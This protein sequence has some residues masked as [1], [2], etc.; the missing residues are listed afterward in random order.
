MSAPTIV[1]V[2][3]RSLWREYVKQTLGPSCRVVSCGNCEVAAD[4]LG[5]TEP[6]LLIL[7]YLLVGS[8]PFPTAADFCRHVRQTWPQ[9]PVVLFTGAWS[10]TSPD[11]RREL[12][13]DLGV[14]VVFKD[15]RDGTLD[16]LAVA[17]AEQLAAQS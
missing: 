17:V 2:D 9:I 16:D 15:R 12:E 3:D 13:D 5:T 14:R 11:P 8:G 1:H 6:D 10:G 4:L 7:D